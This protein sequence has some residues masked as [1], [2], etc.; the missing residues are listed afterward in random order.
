MTGLVND[1]NEMLQEERTIAQMRKKLK[2]YSVENS[3][4]IVVEFSSADQELAAKIPNDDRCANI[5]TLQR[6][7][8]EPV[9][10]GCDQMAGA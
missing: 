2:V 10:L 1:P 4:I 5:L 8:Q 6:A 9:Q 3:R 7:G